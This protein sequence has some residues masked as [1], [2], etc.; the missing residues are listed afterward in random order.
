M[1]IVEIYTDGACSGNPG[2]GGVGIVM[3]AGGHRKEISCAYGLTTNNRME[4]LAAILALEALK[5]PCKVRLHS[6]SRY[7]VDAIEKGWVA[8]WQANNWMR[9]KKDPA[10]NVDLWKRLL[11]LLDT[12]QVDFV[13][14]RGHADN[15]ENNRC[16][17]LARDAITKGDFAEDEGYNNES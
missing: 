2:P 4:L 7:L 14:V 16:D 9:N 5:R 3:M 6:D 1:N 11:P 8:R 10:V 17:A 12:H 15:V 13:W